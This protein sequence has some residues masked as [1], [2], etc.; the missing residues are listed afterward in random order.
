M[1][2]SA[3]ISSCGLYRYRLTRELGGDGPTVMFVMVNPSTADAQD[4]DQTISK[5]IGFS[6]RL[7]ASRLLVGNKFAFRATDIREVRGAR[8]PIG[9]DNDKHLWVMMSEA[10]MVIAA[11]GALNKLPEALRARWKDIVR[12]A[13]DLGRPLC[14]IGTNADKHPKHPQMTGYN[15]PVTP[16]AVPWFAGRRRSQE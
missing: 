1:A 11:W 14:C 4:D 16:W 2:G 10:D 7:G 12:M 9:P 13:D 15:V 8:D 3:V 6:T 5:C